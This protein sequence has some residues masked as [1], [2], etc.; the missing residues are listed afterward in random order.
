MGSAGVLVLVFAIFILPFS[1]AK[2]G[3][4]V[5]PLVI[6]S[7]FLAM[8][9]YGIYL[10]LFF[11]V[12]ISQ[13]EITV[14]NKICNSKYD[15]SNIAGYFDYTH[16]DKKGRS[17]KMLVLQFIDGSNIYFDDSILGKNY[18]VIRENISNSY[19]D[20]GSTI[21]NEYIVNKKIIGLK[22]AS[23]IGI[24]VFLFGSFQFSNY[25]SEDYDYEILECSLKTNPLFELDR[26]SRISRI[27]FEVFEFPAI[28]L[29]QVKNAHNFLDWESTAKIGDKL[30][31]EISKSDYEDSILNQSNTEFSIN[32][33]VGVVELKR[34][35]NS[36]GQFVY[37]ENL[38]EER[39]IPLG[40][41]ILGLLYYLYCIWKIKGYNTI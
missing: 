24:V 1:L 2:G 39:A 12:T 33:P 6:G 5:L 37:K 18:N 30:T 19:K 26:Y 35:R 13:L 27:N 11:R 36:R 23:Y 34:L 7:T 9:S 32:Y 20:L 3:V 10:A 29:S 16:L 17:A 4:M 41:M 15:T 14:G 21:K 8:G 25:I 40:A 38:F 31:I 22:I 28:T